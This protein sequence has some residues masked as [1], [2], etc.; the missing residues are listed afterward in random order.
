MSLLLTV[1]Y[2]SST[3]HC[4]TL[5]QLLRLSRTSLRLF[6]PRAG[7]APLTMTRLDPLHGPQD[8]KA[9]VCLA[10]WQYRMNLIKAVQEALFPIP[11]SDGCTLLYCRTDNSR[12]SKIINTPHAIVDTSLTKS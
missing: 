7:D 5:H 2:G 4:A 10:C 9:A 12:G 6:E 3:T 11:C 1:K 8:V